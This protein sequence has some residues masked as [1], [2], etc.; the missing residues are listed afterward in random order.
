M[1]LFVLQRLPAGFVAKAKNSIGNKCFL[2]GP[3]ME[4]YVLRVKKEG[5]EWSFKGGWKDFCAAY[6]LGPGYSVRLK[7]TASQYFEVE[8]Y[9]MMTEEPAFEMTAEEIEEKSEGSREIQRKQRAEKKRAKENRAKADRTE[10]KTE[11]DVSRP[12]GPARRV[13]RPAA[14]VSQWAEGCATT[15]HGISLNSLTKFH[16]RHHLRMRDLVEVGGKQELMNRLGKYI[17]MHGEASA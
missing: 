7:Y 6:N 4:L 14:S 16:L 13:G 5:D 12:Q 8:I 15:L 3:K 9:D 17:A 2:N 10:V 11:P 1:H